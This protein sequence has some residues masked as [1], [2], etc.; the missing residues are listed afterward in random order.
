MKVRNALPEIPFGL[1]TQ[2]GF[3]GLWGRSIGWR[4]VNYSLNPY[5]SDVNPGLVEKVHALGKKVVTWTVN[6]ETDLKRMINLGV[7]GIIS[8]DP[9]MVLR[10]LGK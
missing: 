2:R 3:M 8:D 9:A 6:N 10:L 5:Y 7:D 4:L 1:L